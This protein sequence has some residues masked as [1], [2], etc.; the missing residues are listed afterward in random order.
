M[1]EEG[2]GPIW[3]LAWLKRY[4]RAYAGHGFGSV[5]GTLSPVVFLCAVLSY[6]LHANHNSYYYLYKPTT[7]MLV[8]YIGRLK[9]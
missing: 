2:S 3:W 4:E 7:L 1:I 5:D 9:P 6:S 8:L